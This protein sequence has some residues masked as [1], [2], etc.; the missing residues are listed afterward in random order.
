MK[1]EVKSLLKSFK[2]RVINI[3]YKQ[4]TINKVLMYSSL[5]ISYMTM[6]V[7]ALSKEAQEELFRVIGFLYLFIM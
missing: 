5:V 3:F 4:T 7:G 1:N 6:P 2:S